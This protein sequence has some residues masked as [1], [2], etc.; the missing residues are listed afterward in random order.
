MHN[1]YLAIRL[2][3]DR[4]RLR[5][6]RIWNGVVT[7]KAMSTWLSAMKA[8]ADWVSE[9][10]GHHYK[11]KKRYSA[12]AKPHSSRRCHDKLLLD[13]LGTWQVCEVRLAKS[14][15]F[16]EVSTLPHIFRSRFEG[17]GL[18]Q[19]Y[20]GTPTPPLGFSQHNSFPAIFTVR[21]LRYSQH[22]LSDITTQLLPH[23]TYY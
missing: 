20:N 11:M 4:L 12:V 10:T 13:P 2:S 15:S 8:A 7:R 9:P 17:R 1:P 23:E 19:V 22:D 5:H 3:L 14:A 18:E 16:L 6:V 21:L